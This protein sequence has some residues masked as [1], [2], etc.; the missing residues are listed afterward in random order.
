MVPLIAKWYRQDL[1]RARARGEKGSGLPP[2]FRLWFSVFGAPAV[3]ISLFWMG[4][5][6]RADVSIWSPLAAS[7]LCGFGILTIFISTYQYLIDTYEL[8]AASALASVTVVRYV[9]AGGMVVVAIPMYRN[10]SVKWTLTL[11]GCLSAV[12]VPIPYLLLR[13]GRKIRNLSKY[14][15]DY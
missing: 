7:V 14:A 3:P 10:L 2:E 5:T 8:Y 4:W 11:L 1:A 13:Y 12:M 15:V 9:A 6:A